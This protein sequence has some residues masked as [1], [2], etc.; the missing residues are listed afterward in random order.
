MKTTTYIPQFKII[1][2][3]VFV[4]FLASLS[5]HPPTAAFL[6]VF[7]T[8]YYFF[9]TGFFIYRLYYPYEKFDFIQLFSY[10]LLLS[11]SINSLTFYLLNRILGTPMTLYNVILTVTGILAVII[12]GHIYRFKRILL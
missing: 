10:S 3:V 5:F 4:T 9:F 7:G 8:F 12:A 2:T 6:K 1:V 11:I